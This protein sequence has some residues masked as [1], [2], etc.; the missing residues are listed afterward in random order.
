MCGKILKGISRGFDWRV[1]RLNNHHIFRIPMAAAIKKEPL[2]FTL[3]NKE[4]PTETE[5]NR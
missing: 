4:D 3:I 5:V 2:A 1:T